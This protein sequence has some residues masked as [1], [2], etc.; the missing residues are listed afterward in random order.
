MRT[1]PH[2]KALHLIAGAAF[3]FAGLVLASATGATGL[4]PGAVGV[5]LAAAAGV[6]REA[7]NTATGGQWS[8]EDVAYTAGG[9]APVAG[10]AWLATSP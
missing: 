7:Y 1:I 10:A 8:W 2:D 4:I 9:S 6:L 5:A 3:A